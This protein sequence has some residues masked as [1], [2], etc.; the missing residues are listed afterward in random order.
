M[1]N[2]CSLFEIISFIVLKVIR[3]STYQIIIVSCTGSKALL[4]IIVIVSPFSNQSGCRVEFSSE[5]LYTI[6]LKSC[7]GEK[8]GEQIKIR[9][10]YFCFFFFSLGSW[11]MKIFL[12]KAIMHFYSKCRR[13]VNLQLTWPHI[14][15]W[16]LPLTL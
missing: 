1:S 11:R 2:Y 10:C 12:L 14:S 3:A 4:S 6:L 13:T 7:N 16:W 5:K 15:R 8:T 9:P